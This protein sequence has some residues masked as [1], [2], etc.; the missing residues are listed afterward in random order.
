MSS[1]FSLSSAPVPVP[2]ASRVLAAG[3][4]WAA[5]G[6]ALGA[7]GAHALSGRLNPA[8]LAI[9]ETA[10]R[11]QMYVALALL[12]LGAA[13]YRGWPVRLLW[14]GSAVFSGSLYLLVATNVRVLGAVTP[15]GGLL[16]IV[17]LLW[18]A[19]LSWRKQA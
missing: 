2:H 3:A 8:D 9:F 18:L 14:L 6:I 10:V 19:W 7:F 15:L 13:G 16:M 5:L 11:Y 12:A 4:V 17:G 1:G